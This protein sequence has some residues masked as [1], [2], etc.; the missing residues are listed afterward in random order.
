MLFP[1]QTCTDKNWISVEHYYQAVWRSGKVLVGQKFSI[2]GLREE[3]KTGGGGRQG[4]LTPPTFPTG[5]MELVG[6]IKAATKSL[7]I[8]AGEVAVGRGSVSPAITK[9]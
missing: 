6:S 1:S 5:A 8:M 3:I 7:Y 4:T 2:S 9:T